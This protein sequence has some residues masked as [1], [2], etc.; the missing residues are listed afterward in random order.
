[1]IM[2]YNIFYLLICVALLFSCTA[3]ECVDIPMTDATEKGG[4]TE[5]IFNLSIPA[6]ELPTTRT[7]SN[8]SQ[9]NS[10]KIWIFKGK[11]ESA[12]FYKEVKDKDVS[13]KMTPSGAE[14]L[15]ILLPESEEEITLS[16]IANV[17]DVTTPT[18]GTPK[19]GALNTLEYSID[20]AEK[21]GMPMYGEQTLIVRQGLRTDIRLRKAMAKIQ[22]D[23]SSAS[24][25]KLFQL[26][27]VELLNINKRG[28]VVSG[29]ITTAE[30]FVFKQDVEG[31]NCIFYIPEISK[32]NG[33]RKVSVLIK[34]KH[35]DHT[36]SSYYRLEFI[37]REGVLVENIERNYK[38]VFLITNVA[39]SSGHTNRDDAINS[40]ASNVSG[41]EMVLQVIDNEGIMDITTDGSYFLG[42]TASS[43]TAK[44]NTDYYFANISVQG[45]N[46]VGWNMVTSE[47]PVGVSTSMDKFDPTVIGVEPNIINSVWI[48]IERDSATTGQKVNVYIYS[49]GIRK[50]IEIT[51]P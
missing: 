50:K 48:Y 43:I 22:I 12:T 5:V 49:G 8:D 19:A 17:P 7:I 41:T 10:Y 6:Q 15:F 1:M 16:V 34:G 39:S 23:A 42:V 35:K 27:S 9:I 28:K 32:V 24:D 33:D 47:F 20:S 3:E 4:Q 14:Q 51:I 25:T 44:Y 26:E 36:M 2:K 40:T 29:I 46:P 21:N 45:N 11:D 13:L 37:K 30:D 18:E 31:D 38:Y